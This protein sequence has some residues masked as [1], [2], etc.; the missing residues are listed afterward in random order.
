MRF[1]SFEGYGFR[2]KVRWLVNVAINRK[3]ATLG[4]LMGK[5]EHYQRGLRLLDPLNRGFR[6]NLRKSLL[7]V[8][9]VKMFDGGLVPCRFFRHGAISDPL[10]EPDDC[11]AELV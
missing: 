11:V 3:L 8:G 2:L 9:D 5:L 7:M 10:V 4:N 6:W 1:L